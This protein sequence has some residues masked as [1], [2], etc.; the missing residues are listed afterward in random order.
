MS[1]VLLRCE[2]VQKKYRVSLKTIHVLKGVTMN[3]HRGE[4]CFIVGRSGSGKSTLLHILGGLD[5]PTQGSVYI[6]GAKLHGV[7]DRKKA[8]LRNQKI[9]F[10][11]QFYHL[12]PELTVWENVLLPAL[13]GGRKA[14]K[15]AEELLHLVGLSKRKKHLPSQLSGGE[16]QRVALARALINEP[17]VVLCDEP[18]GNLDEETACTM[19]ALIER[20]NQEKKQT[21]CIV[22]HDESVV[23]KNQNMYR[24]RDGVLSH[25]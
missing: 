8:L 22:T 9:G 12:L 19:Y 13:I 25:V 6:E 10:V 7:S 20:L 3:I 1:N 14:H 4:M 24:L 17:D 18:T 2:N 15:A 21:F 5:T 11:F 23:K 16:Q